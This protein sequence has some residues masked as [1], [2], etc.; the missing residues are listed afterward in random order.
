MSPDDGA[1]HDNSPQASGLKASVPRNVSDQP[2]MRSKK[3]IYSSTQSSVTPSNAAKRLEMDRTRDK[4][5]NNTAP[6]TFISPRLALPV[7]PRLRLEDAINSVESPLYN[8]STDPDT[9]THTPVLDGVDALEDGLKLHKATNPA[10]Y[11]PVPQPLRETVTRTTSTSGNSRLLAHWA[12]QLAKRRAN[13]SRLDVYTRKLDRVASML[14]NQQMPELIEGQP[15]SEEQLLVLLGISDAAS[16][17][18]ADEAASPG[19]TPTKPSLSNATSIEDSYQPLPAPSPFASLERAASATPMQS[20]RIRPAPSP[21]HRFLDSIP[22]I[23][24]NEYKRPPRPEP[25]HLLLQGT[26]P[27]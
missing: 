25:T 17:I 26:S 8:S 22:P 5:R 14:A 10:L 19:R 21:A 23:N 4:A 24:P 11:R 7:R 20:V 12:A 3:L 15:P 2:R 27:W 1:H 13:E 6:T 9:L 18:N 16:N